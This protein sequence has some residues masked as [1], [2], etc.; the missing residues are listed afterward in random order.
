MLNLVKTLPDGIDLQGIYVKEEKPHPGKEA[1][2]WFLTT[3]ELVET[4][5]EAYKWKVL[6][7][8]VN[9]TKK[10]PKNPYTIKEAI[11]YLERLGGRNGY[12]VM[13][14]LE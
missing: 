12:P 2:K 13:A 14:R 6:Y 5:E 4:V 8:A 10:E 1:I 9:K 11:D 7:S 3:S